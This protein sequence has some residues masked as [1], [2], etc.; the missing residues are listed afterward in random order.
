MSLKSRPSALAAAALGCVGAVALSACGSSSTGAQSAQSP[1]RNPN[2]T[3]ASSA[4]S[5]SN[6]GGSATTAGQVRSLQVSSGSGSIV[7]KG[8]SGALVVDER[9]GNSTVPAPHKLSNGTL[10][11]GSQSDS[12]S[13]YIEVPKSAT[14]NATNSRGAIQLSSLA[15]QV[16]A[17]AAS[18]TISGQDLSAQTAT[19]S[20]HAGGIDTSFAAPPRSVAAT[21][22][23]G[24]V[25]I[26]VPRSASYQVNAH[27][28]RGA[29]QVTVPKNASAQHVVTATAG[30][31][32]VMVM[33]I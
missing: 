7:V 6:A 28:G 22:Q 31:G 1:A 10:S 24:S 9:A 12:N 3:P 2:G 20:S 11:V 13:Y 27:S 30:S 17:T 18:G 29:A 16:Q 14:V 25:I 4:T 26:R 32:P 33:P 15:G 19:L 21:A 23:T 5:G 8:T